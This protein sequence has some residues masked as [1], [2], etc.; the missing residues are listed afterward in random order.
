MTAKSA[1]RNGFAFSGVP[2]SIPGAS[3]I[4]LQFFFNVF[5]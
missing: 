3:T 4:F 2:V 5:I 1:P